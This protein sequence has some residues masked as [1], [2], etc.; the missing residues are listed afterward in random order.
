MES[1]TQGAILS[2][3]QAWDMARANVADAAA[4][5]NGLV[6]SVARLQGRSLLI[7]RSDTDG[8]LTVWPA[9][10]GTRRAR[11]FLV[12]SHVVRSNGSLPR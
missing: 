4:N 2:R 10:K 6:F 1:F 9:K 11:S 12:K 5:H 8:T 7:V 3:R